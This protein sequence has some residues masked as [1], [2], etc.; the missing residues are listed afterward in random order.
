MRR[1]KSLAG[2]SIYT[3]G[4][5]YVLCTRYALQAREIYIISNLPAGKYID[6]ALGQKYR[7]AQQYIDK[8]LTT[9]RR[10]PPFL[11]VVFMYRQDVPSA[12]TNMFVKICTGGVLPPVNPSGFCVAKATSPTGEAGVPF[13]TRMFVIWSYEW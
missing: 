3:F 4:V 9:R 10:G 5:R 11:R 2:F 8:R 6:F 1:Y 12:T 13:P 7:I